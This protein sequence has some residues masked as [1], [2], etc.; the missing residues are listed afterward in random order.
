MNNI[1][2]KNSK[3]DWLNFTLTVLV[4]KGPDALKIIPLCKL[5][6]V[7]KG[8]FY[9]HFKNR[10]EF[11]ELLMAY[12]FKKMTV[13]FIEQANT[14]SS[15]LERL[16]KLD[17]IIA[18]HN[19]L[20]ELHIRA[21]ALK[22]P[23]IAEHL[24]FIDSQRQQYLSQCYVE[25]GIEKLLAD[26]IAVMAYSSFLGMQQIYPR[27]PIETVLRVTTLGSKKFIEDHLNSLNINNA[28]DRF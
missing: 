25:L 17:T 11:I 10:A 8:S 4:E 19:L 6:G 2:T 7:S 27:L 22:E 13:D 26:D 21:W 15:P 28:M 20:T 12:W 1:S 18:G 24:G 16:Q 9:H 3:D 14:E 23:K 5:K